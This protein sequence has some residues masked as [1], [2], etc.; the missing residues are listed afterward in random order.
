MQ[1]ALAAAS[2]QPHSLWPAVQYMMGY[3]EWPGN[4]KMSCGACTP[5]AHVRDRY[6]SERASAAL[7]RAAETIGGHFIMLSISYVPPA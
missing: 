3:E 2:L 4:C 1:C 7:L 6:L 5:P